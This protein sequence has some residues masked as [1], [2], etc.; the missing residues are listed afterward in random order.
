M[1][2][3]V[4]IIVFFGT[5]DMIRSLLVPPDITKETVFR[6]KFLRPIKLSLHFSIIPLS[7]SYMFLLVVNL[8]PFG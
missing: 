1:F 3:L 2:C 6:V 5:V 4:F 7:V 8:L